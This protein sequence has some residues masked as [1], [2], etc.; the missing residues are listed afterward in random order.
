[1]TDTIMAALVAVGL[2]MML[3]THAR[4]ARGFYVNGVTAVDQRVGELGVYR[5]HQVPARRWEEDKPVGFH[6][7]A[8]LPGEGHEYSGMI[9]CT[10]GSLPIV[11]D[12]QVVGCQPGGWHASANR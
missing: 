4:C 9:F 1:M 2:A 10:G 8:D 11:V 3:P 5:C 7:V 12:E 6:P